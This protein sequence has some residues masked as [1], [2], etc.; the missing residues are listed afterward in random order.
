MVANW[1]QK[2]KERLCDYQLGVKNFDSTNHLLAKVTLNKSL[3]NIKKYHSSAINILTQIEKLS[4]CKN[5][6]IILK[7]YS[8]D[9][10]VNKNIQDDFNAIIGLKTKKIN[11]SNGNEIDIINKSVT[12]EMSDLLQLRNKLFEPKRSIIANNIVGRFFKF[13][14]YG[15]PTFFFSNFSNIN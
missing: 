15:E 1:S 3:N 10:L 11:C 5:F 7:P 6:K 9:Q 8:K 14:S 4:D 13:N 12:R 2:N